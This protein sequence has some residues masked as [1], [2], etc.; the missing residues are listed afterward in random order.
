MTPQ[1]AAKAIIEVLKASGVASDVYA[2]MNALA[3]DLIDAG[4]DL[5][6][7]EEGLT[8]GFEN[9]WFD[10]LD[11]FISVTSMGESFYWSSLSD[12]IVH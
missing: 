9:G 4:M 1:E 6:E 5:D 7:I 2:S 12:R 3:D 10:L 8:I 11:G